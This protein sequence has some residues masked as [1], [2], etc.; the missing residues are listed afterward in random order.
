M[1]FILFLDI[2]FFFMVKQNIWKSALNSSMNKSKADT[3]V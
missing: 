2:F 3:D 1:F